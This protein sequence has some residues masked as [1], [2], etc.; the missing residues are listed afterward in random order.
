ML[1]LA[2]GT[3][4][5]RL[6][7]RT[8]QIKHYRHNPSDNSGLNSNDVNWTGEDRTGTFWV[9]TN[10]GLDAFD[11]ETGKVT[12]HIPVGDARQ[13]SFYE[14]RFGVFWIL[15]FTGSGLAVLDRQTNL[16]T[17]YSF[18]EREPERGAFTGVMGMLEDR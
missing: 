11:R 1:W 9:G 5:Y 3:G 6:D 12:F 7:P 2:T 16:L 15:S 18:Y 13:I 8:G 17:R 14:D 4:L 10:M